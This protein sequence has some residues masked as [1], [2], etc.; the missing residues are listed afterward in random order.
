[1][2]L[3]TQSFSLPR[4]DWQWSRRKY[5]MAVVNATPD[6]FSAD[7][8]FADSSPN[9]VQIG[10]V[11]AKALADGADILDI[12]AESTRPGSRAIP[13][14]EQIARLTPVFA[15]FQQVLSGEG[16]SDRPWCVSLDTS[17][18]EVAEWGL[19]QGVQMIND[20]Q[21]GRDQEL[22]KVV[23]KHQAEIV[24]MHNSAIEDH[25][26]DGEN[27]GLSYAADTDSDI[28]ARVQE[29]LIRKAER[30][31]LAGILPKNII[32]DPGIGFG[33][34]VADNLRLISSSDRLAELGYPIL[35]GASRKSFLGKILN[36]ESDQRLEASLMVHGE[37]LMGG[38]NIIRV[39]DVRSHHRICCII[40]A[41][42]HPE[43][44][45]DE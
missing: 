8:L 37:S 2:P 34:S 14:Q 6:S 38:A 24:L 29:S 17:D 45:D 21:G 11:L 39:H 42:Q 36:L 25:L 15:A 7:G 10:D 9:T 32:L 22:L 3:K 16:F 4:L 23:A 40:E 44:Y 19:K 26:V 30:A 20:V 5:V 33:K 1:M 35:M 12:G 18:A 31:K 28:V 27:L 43:V 13:A 41:L